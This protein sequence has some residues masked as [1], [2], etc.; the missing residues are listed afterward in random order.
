MNYWQ[1]DV[2]LKMEIGRAS[3]RERVE[4]TVGAVRVKKKTHKKQKR[5]RGEK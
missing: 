5:R 1:V 3:C 2:K 4:I